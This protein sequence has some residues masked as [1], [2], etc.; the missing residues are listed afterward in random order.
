MA[1]LALAVS[2]VLALCLREGGIGG[3]LA[4]PISSLLVPI[5]IT[6]EAFVYPANP[7]VRMWWPIAVTVG[8]LY[9]LV[10]AGLGYALAAF[11][12]KRR[13]S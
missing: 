2:F 4:I 3:L 10:A 8:T 11:A 1:F 5:E 12:Q 6:V 13:R 9:G 7:E